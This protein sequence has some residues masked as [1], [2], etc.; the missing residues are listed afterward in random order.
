[1]IFL[2]FLN[3]PLSAIQSLLQIADKKDN[4]KLWELKLKL[5]LLM[6]Q[7]ERS[8][9]IQ[10]SLTQKNMQSLVGLN[11]QMFRNNLGILL[12]DLP[13]MTKQLT[14]MLISSEIEI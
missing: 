12:S 1:M 13:L 5:K 7:S 8:L 14:E 2:L 6:K 10:L 4:K 3:T 11:G 9:V